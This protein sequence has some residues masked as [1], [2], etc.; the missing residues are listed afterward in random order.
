MQLLNRLEA[1]LRL[2]HRFIIFVLLGGSAALLNLGLRYVANFFLTFEVSI[3]IAYGLSMIY[4]FLIFKHLVFKPAIGKATHVEFSR[5]A[6]VNVASFALVMLVSVTFE[7]VILPFLNI[8]HY[9]REIAHFIG[10]ASPVVTSY[11]AHR[12]FTFATETG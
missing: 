7:Y 5:F 2:P 3:A 8:T 9:T 11:Y 4:G 1:A 10:V 12:R 6:L